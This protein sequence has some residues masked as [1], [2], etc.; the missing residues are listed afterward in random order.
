MGSTRESLQPLYARALADLLS[1]GTQ[2][3]SSR[4]HI[5]CSTYHLIDLYIAQHPC[6]QQQRRVIGWHIIPLSLIAER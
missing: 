2:N 5:L 3:V 6:R 1:T 4:K